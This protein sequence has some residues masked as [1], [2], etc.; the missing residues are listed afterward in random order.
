[1]MDTVIC[2]LHTIYLVRSRCPALMRYS[3]NRSSLFPL[4]RKSCAESCV[5]PKVIYGLLC[6]R[7]GYSSSITGVFPHKFLI[8]II[9]M[10]PGDNTDSGIE[11][12]SSSNKSLATTGSKEMEHEEIDDEVRTVILHVVRFL[13]FLLRP[14]LKAY[15]DDNFLNLLRLY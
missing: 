10:A 14:S 8:L 11:S 7:V 3:T 5:E 4:F 12:L 15:R 1:M 6:T 2:N 9:R 13:T